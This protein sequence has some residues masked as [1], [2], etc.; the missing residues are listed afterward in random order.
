MCFCVLMCLNV[1]LSR[2]AFTAW[3]SSCWLI[4]LH[5][6]LL[7]WSSYSELHSFNCSIYLVKK[8]SYNKSGPFQPGTPWKQQKISIELQGSMVEAL[9]AIFHFS[10]WKLYRA[11]SWMKKKSINSIFSKTRRPR[12][13]LNYKIYIHAAK[14]NGGEWKPARSC[15]VNGD[16]QW[17]EWWGGH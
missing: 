15:M 9:S 11:R 6:V 16:R 2:V 13:V 14:S 12:N 17:K 4:I 5:K 3:N 8:F 7:T 10:S 1:I